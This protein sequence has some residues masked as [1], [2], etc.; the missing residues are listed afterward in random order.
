MAIDES[1][2]GDSGQK[3]SASVASKPNSSDCSGDATIAQC[4]HA[5]QQLTFIFQF[6]PKQAQEAIDAVGPDVTVAYNYILDNGGQD[7]GGTI[8][9]ISD[10]P[11]VS[12]CV[13]LDA[14]RIEYENVC[15]HMQEEGFTKGGMK[16][17]TIN[18]ACPSG[19]NWL[20]LKCGAVRCSRYINGH[21]RDHWEITK[22]K[23]NDY[24]HC[25][26]VSL[27][28]LSVWCYECSAYLDDS[29]LKPILKSL[30]DKKFGE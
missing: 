5:M 2:N 21:C 17:D 24:G 27:E 14:N 11:H 29:S 12:D 13:A 16:G 6:T 26:A 15:T 10:C 23:S 8:L 3:K 19:E 30:E 9:P 25:I 7:R 1:S 22:A 28:D 20:C 4:M 18:G